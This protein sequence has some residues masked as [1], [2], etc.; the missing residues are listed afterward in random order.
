ML[1][2]ISSLVV[3]GRCIESRADMSFPEQF[4]SNYDLQQMINELKGSSN[5]TSMP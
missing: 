4:I 5:A 2:V 1:S 3:L